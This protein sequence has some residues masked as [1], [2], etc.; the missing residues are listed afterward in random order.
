MTSLLRPSDTA[1][2]FFNGFEQ[3][4]EVRAVERVNTRRLDDI[5]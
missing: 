3:F 5:P 2:K 4:G 1:L